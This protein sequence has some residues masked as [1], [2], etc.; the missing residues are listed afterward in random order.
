MRPVSE[1]PGDSDVLLEKNGRT[2]LLWRCWFFFNRNGGGFNGCFYK[3][4]ISLF[5]GLPWSGGGG[6]GERDGTRR[7]GVREE[8]AH[9]KYFPFKAERDRGGEEEIK[10]EKEESQRGREGERERGSEKWK[11]EKDVIQS[12]ETPRRS[13]GP[14]PTGSALAGGRAVRNAEA[15]DPNGCGLPGSYR[16]INPESRTS[17]RLITDTS[18]V[19]NIIFIFC[20]QFT[21]FFYYCSSHKHFLLLFSF[22]CTIKSKHDTNHFVA[23]TKSS[24]L[25]H[26]HLW[27]I[28]N[29]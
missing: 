27:L 11:K 26:F 22:K 2:F 8:G 24:R 1:A 13:H 29:S 28:R 20:M 21:N 7:D 10:K 5:V 23:F 17:C 18:S 12:I 3:C 9:T 15:W 6:G 25:V 4:R 16:Q 14:R 19:Y